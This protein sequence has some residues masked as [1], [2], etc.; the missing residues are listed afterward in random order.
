MCVKNLRKFE[1]YNY[2]L[3]VIVKN[4]LNEV[5]GY[6]VL[7]E[8]KLLFKNKKVIVLVIGVLLVDKFI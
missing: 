1:S 7:V 6:V 3:E 5:I 2:E 8:V 4:E